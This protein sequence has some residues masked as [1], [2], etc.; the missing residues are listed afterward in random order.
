MPFSCQELYVLSECREMGFLTAKRP[1]FMRRTIRDL[2]MYRKA[3]FPLRELTEKEH[4]SFFSGRVPS[5]VLEKSLE[6]AIAS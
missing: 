3:A 5:A 4:L 2:R 6:A 1:N